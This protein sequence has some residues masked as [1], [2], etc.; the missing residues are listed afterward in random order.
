MKKILHFLTFCL[1]LGAC[2]VLRLPDQNRAIQ[3]ATSTRGGEAPGHVYGQ[4]P[5]TDTP[6]ELSKADP[7]ELSDPVKQNRERLMD[8]YRQTDWFPSRYNF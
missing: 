8:K 6:G 2:Y 3:P 5:D 7:A 4:L 1:F